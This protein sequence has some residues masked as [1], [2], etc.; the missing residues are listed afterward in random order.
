MADDPAKARLV[1]A[2]VALLVHDLKA[3]I[4]RILAAREYIADDNPPPEMLAKALA[5]IDA[6][7]RALER[8]IRNLA[9]LDRSD[10][11][12]LLLAAAVV[13]VNA[14]CS[15]IAARANALAAI[16]KSGVHVETGLAREWPLVRIDA[17]LVERAVENLVEDATRYGAGH[18]P[19]RLETGGSATTLRI[20]I[21]DNGPR[22]RTA[23][24]GLRFCQI[25]VDAHGGTLHVEAAADGARV[26]IEIPRARGGSISSP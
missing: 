5:I 11:G 2:R 17:D 14:M 3:P 9:D 15:S 1:P 22:I 4:A 26:V 8:M 13:D 20:T 18:G 19:V 25:V 16:V 24:L 23:G 7:A 21:S 10:D 6:S 12:P